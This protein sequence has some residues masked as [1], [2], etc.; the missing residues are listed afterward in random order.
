MVRL[1]H[2]VSDTALNVGEVEPDFDAA[3]VGA[4]GTDWR[5]DAGTQVAGRADVAGK[6][7]VHFA[8]LGNFVHGGV[9]NLLLC[10]ETGAHGPFVEKVKERAGFDETDGFSVG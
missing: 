6:F 10:V 7:G 8:D 2:T 5:S 3:E 1:C 4:F 9:V